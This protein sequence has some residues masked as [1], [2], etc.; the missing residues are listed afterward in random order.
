M[1]IAS[2]LAWQAQQRQDEGLR[3]VLGT[4]TAIAATTLE[5]LIDGEPLAVARCRA[6]TWATPGDIALILRAGRRQ[7]AITVLGDGPATTPAP[8]TSPQ[9]EP[10]P[11][12]ATTLTFRPASTGWW[13][14][15]AGWSG[16]T[17]DLR[18]ANTPA[19]EYWGAAYWGT[20]PTTG[21]G[22]PAAA[23]VRL[24]D[25]TAW[26]TGTHTPTLTLLAGATRPTGPPVTYGQQITGPTTTPGQVTEFALP[27]SWA[28]ALGEGTA[29][30]LAV[31]ATSTTPSPGTV[32]TGH[33]LAG[34][35]AS[36]SA[37]ELTLTYP[38]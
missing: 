5:V 12:P 1:D 36:P 22:V 6:I 27:A 21:P 14:T 23:A 38:T 16:P 29:G 19:G 13:H 10:P 8:E 37:M 2:A 11:P 4:V 34:L 32:F 26:A 31:R 9:D 15:T 28:H 24:I 35:R 25:T 17:E 30:G 3:L 33:T 20:P 7:W 18:A